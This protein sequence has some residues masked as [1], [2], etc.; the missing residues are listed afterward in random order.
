MMNPLLLDER[1]DEIIIEDMMYQPINEELK[2]RAYVGEDIEE[3]I[4]DLLSHI[5]SFNNVKL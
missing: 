4:Y 2:I 1:Y 5:E 3:A